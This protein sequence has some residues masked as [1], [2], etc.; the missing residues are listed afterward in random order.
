MDVEVELVC[1]R[2]EQETVHRAIIRDGYLEVLTCSVCGAVT[3]ILGTARPQAK[4]VGDPKPEIRFA[5]FGF[6]G[7]RKPKVMLGSGPVLIEGSIQVHAA[8]RAVAQSVDV[9]TQATRLREADCHLIRLPVLDPLQLSA[10]KP[11]HLAT[12]VPVAVDIGTQLDLLSHAAAAQPEAVIATLES[13]AQADLLGG[14]TAAPLFVRIGR[15]DEGTEALAELAEVIGRKLQAAGV[16]QLVL[17]LNVRDLEHFADAYRAVRRR[18]QVPLRLELTS[19]HFSADHARAFLSLGSLVAEGLGS[20]LA[21]AGAP[22]AAKGVDEITEL[23]KVLGYLELPYGHDRARTFRYYTRRTLD[24]LITKPGRMA[25]ELG[26]DPNVFV[27][28]LPRRALTKPLRL[29]Q[30]FRR[31]FNKI[32]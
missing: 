7:G 4:A 9:M 26:A 28:S 20:I 18:M 24:R 16:T 13:A 23:L 12:L 19:E 3:R 8:A 6:G 5:P 25:A 10:L 32:S 31:I 30:E 1:N 2:C 11:I 22:D 17:S 15:G 29:V 14:F 27:S 21:P